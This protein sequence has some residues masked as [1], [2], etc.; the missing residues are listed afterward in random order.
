MLGKKCSGA[1][2][3]CVTLACQQAAPSDLQLP[4]SNGLSRRSARLPCASARSP[5][6][7][8]LQKVLGVCFLYLRD[9]IW[10]Q[11]VRLNQG[12][13]AGLTQGP[14]AS[15]ELAP[16]SLAPLVEMSDRHL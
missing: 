10:N 5:L 4:A 3:L 9:R 13:S 12:H 16:Y 8:F 2:A 15:P 7:L 1:S 14:S 6:R 11:N